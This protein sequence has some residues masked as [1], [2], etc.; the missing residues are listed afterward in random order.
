MQGA[1]FRNLLGRMTA[2]ICAGDAEGAVACFT[3]DGVYHDGF[4]GEFA[5]R[6]EIVRMLRDFFYRDARDFEWKLM[7]AVCDGRLGYARY[8]FS[9]VSKIAGAE[10]RRT[11]FP[12]I[13]CCRLEDGLIA[14]YEE[15]FE[16]APV[17]VQL[18]FPEERIL[19][20]LKR[21][22]KKG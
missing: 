16:R 9:Y 2:A 14:R 12:G 13:S 6:P 4:Y 22:A 3:P 5:G 15:S 17:L 21:W 1:A 8:E 19:K 10:G 18:G 20:S 11:G 7:D